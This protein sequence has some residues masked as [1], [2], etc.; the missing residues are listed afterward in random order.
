MK[1]AF[2]IIK[3]YIINFKEIKEGVYLNIFL[4]Q[5][6]VDSIQKYTKEIFN[7]YIRKTIS[8]NMNLI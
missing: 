7:I 3:L 2:I 4:L 8:K 6:T 5:K 1:L